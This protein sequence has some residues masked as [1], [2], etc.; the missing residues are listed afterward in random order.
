[1]KQKL[2]GLGSFIFPAYVVVAMVA[3][4]FLAPNVDPDAQ[5][6]DKVIPLLIT[7][8]IFLFLSVLG[9]WFFIIFDIIHAAKNPDFSGGAKAGWICAIWF[10]NIFAIPVYWM[11]HLRGNHRTTDS[12]VPSE[13]APSDV[14]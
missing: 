3:L 5:I 13:G 14:Q 11:K 2:L 9:T 4:M 7:G 1:M 8:M 10:L 12:T 6:P